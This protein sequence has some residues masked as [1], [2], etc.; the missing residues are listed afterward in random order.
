M[1]AEQHTASMLR[2]WDI[3][4]V[5]RADLAIRR[6][7]GTMIWHHDLSFGALP[8]GWARAENV[9]LGD[10]YIRPARGYSWPLVFLDDLPAP[11]AI[12]VANKYDALVVETSKAGGCHL[13]M[14]CS[15]ALDEKERY[16][17]QKWLAA[18]IEADPGSVSGEHL[19]RLSGFKNWKRGGPWVNVLDAS[20]RGR[21]WHPKHQAMIQ[22]PDTNVPAKP[23]P[24]SAFSQIT[25]TDSSESGTEWGWVCGLLEAGFDETSVLQMLIDRASHRRGKDVQRYSRRT[26]KQA[27]KR[28][29]C[30]G[31]GV[32]VF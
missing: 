1:T 32:E 22:T 11:I 8:I 7:C 6:H 19:G 12:R 28:T 17:S 21:R 4:G 3:V 14:A 13:W 20:L 15:R 5:S 26:I 9:R 27:I 30:I 16:Q 25:G 10:V 29:S 24:T 31:K 2:W 18:Q 23:T